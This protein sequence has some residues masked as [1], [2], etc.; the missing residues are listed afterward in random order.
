MSSL[1]SLH[2]GKKCQMI[3]DIIKYKKHLKFNERLHY[4]STSVKVIKSALSLS[5]DNELVLAIDVNFILSI[6]YINYYTW[7]MHLCVFVSLHF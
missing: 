4:I 5:I 7:K 2:S 3:K 6:C 1:N